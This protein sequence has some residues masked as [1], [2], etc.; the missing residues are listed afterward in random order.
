MW[1]TPHADEP[2]A[3]SSAPPSRRSCPYWRAS[4]RKLCRH[5]QNFPRGLD[6]CKT[7]YRHYV[8]NAS[9]V[10]FGQ[11]ATWF[12]GHAITG[13]FD[14]TRCFSLRAKAKNCTRKRPLITLTLRFLF[15]NADFKFGLNEVSQRENYMFIIRLDNYFV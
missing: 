2:N 15:E 6:C 4:S 8:I 13:C 9:Q 3:S 5:T 1:C 10:F 11:S 14:S 7:Y 12:T